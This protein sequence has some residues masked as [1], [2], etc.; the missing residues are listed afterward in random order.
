[1][2]YLDY[3][4]KGHIASTHYKAVKGYVM[5]QPD[6]MQNK[7][8]TE[9]RK[10]YKELP[11]NRR[12]ADYSWLRRFILADC[13]TLDSWV[14]TQPDDLKDEFFRKLYLRHFAKD[15]VTFVDKAKT[16]NAYTLL[17]MIGFH[18]CPYCD[19]EYIDIISTIEGDRRT[20]DIDH[21]H[22]KGKD[23]YPLLAMCFYNL[24]PSGKGCNQTMNI[25]SIEANPYDNNIETWSRFVQDTPIG[26]LIDSLDNKELK[27][28]LQT[29]AG[30]AINNAVLAIERRYNNRKYEL[31]RM[32]KLRELFRPE[33]IE[34]KKR[35]GISEE[36]LRV[37]LGEPYPAE[38]GKTIHQKLRHDLL[39]F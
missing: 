34:E 20:Y 6:A 19:E 22:P 37:T 26:Q 4:N 3:P 9:I 23:E 18:V 16:Y 38:R 36:T 28:R 39:G 25:T 1:M 27:I 32:F 2:I 14:K 31:R 24:I 21:F 15:P 33:N 17:D 8:Y 30:M 5:R 12:T 13:R 7:L 11:K 10:L 29:T 35:L